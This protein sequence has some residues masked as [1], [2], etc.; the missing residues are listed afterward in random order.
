MHTRKP[1]PATQ[2]PRTLLDRKLIATYQMTDSPPAQR[3]A[4]PGIRLRGWISANCDGIAPRRAIESA[5]RAAGRIV[6]C[7][8]AVAEVSTEIVSRKCSDP[9]TPFERPP[10][11][12]SFGLSPRYFVP[13]YACEATVTSR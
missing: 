1:R 4:L 12:M 5:E 10:A 7:V 11:K 8:A 6:V 3:V 9:S 13:A 2:S